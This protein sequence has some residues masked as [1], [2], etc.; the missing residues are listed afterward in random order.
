MKA[1]TRYISYL[2][3][4]RGYAILFV[5]LGHFELTSIYLSRFGV[6]VFFFVSGFLITK[7]LIHEYN[8]NNRIMLKDFYLRRLFRLYPALIFMIG[9]T[10][11]VLLLWGFKII[12]PDIFAGLFYF[13]NYYLVYFRPL[14]EKTY[15]MVSNI[16]WSLSVEEHFYFI[17]PILFTLLFAKGKTFLYLL[18][19]SL[20]L[21]L[22]V[23]FYVAWGHSP[24]YYF[25]INYFTTHARG[26][27]I[28][29]GCVSA[30]LLYQYNTAWYLKALQSRWVAAFAILIVLFSL[31]FPSQF[32]RST[33][34][35]SLQGLGMFFIIPA[36]SFIPEQNFLARLV[37]NK[38]ITYV[39][40]L[41]YS[42][43]LFHWVSLKIGNLVFP[44]KNLEWFALVIPL[45]IGL[46]LLSFYGVEKP[47]LKLRK[48]YG[49]HAK[50]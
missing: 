42:L 5:L 33:L 44:V 41:S 27:S 34:A 21:F 40:R 9:C 35:Y 14:T 30:L 49:S 16:L 15:L 39:G 28:I 26:D 7:L 50:A 17:F 18:S 47:F 8:R 3:G 29:Y 24:D 23:R 2:D 31:V 22:A 37:N 36:F 4:L 25:P 10:I 32:L 48:R 11:A 6:T 38:V 12:W 1:D 19:A 43:Y 45:T 13:T 20:V 46:S